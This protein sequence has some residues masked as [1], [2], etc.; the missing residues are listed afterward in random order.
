MKLLW[1]HVSECW[2]PRRLHQGP[3]EHFLL[4]PIRSVKESWKLHSPPLA[5]APPAAP[6]PAPASLSNFQEALEEE[7]CCAGRLPLSSSKAVASRA[8]MSAKKTE[9]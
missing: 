6:A 4:A 9:S 1:Q 2:R 3:I 8:A 5:P 7:T